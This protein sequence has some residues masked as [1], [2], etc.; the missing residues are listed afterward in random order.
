MGEIWYE[1]TSLFQGMATYSFRRKYIAS[2]TLDDGSIVFDDHKA[3]ALWDSYND[4][5][6]CSEFSGILY[7]LSELIQASEL[8][9]LD[10]PFSN[11]EILAVLKDMPSYHAPGPDGFNGAF[12]FKKVLAYYQAVQ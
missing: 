10:E 12:F 9:V 8:P 2:L 6:G 4:R 11:D 5:L 7:D 3:V 1:N